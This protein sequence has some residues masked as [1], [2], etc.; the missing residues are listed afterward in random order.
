MVG[1]LLFELETKRMEKF[2]LKNKLSLEFD[3]V[4]FLKRIIWLR[5]CLGYKDYV[6]WR[7]CL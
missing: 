1:E 5:K 6:L 2:L 3:D 7:R 4:V